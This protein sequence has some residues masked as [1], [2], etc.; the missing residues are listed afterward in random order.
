M[1]RP[2]VNATFPYG[3]DRRIVAT[4]VGGGARVRL[5]RRLDAFADVRLVITGDDAAEMA[6][7]APIRAGL[8]V[9]F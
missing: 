7:L 8:A 6:V 5:H 2:N 1:E 4:Y 3:V 9:R